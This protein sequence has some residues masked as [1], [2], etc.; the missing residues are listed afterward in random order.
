MLA[1]G[2]AGVQE[3][4]DVSEVSPN[5]DQE[6]GGRGSRIGDGQVIDDQLEAFHR[7]AADVG[8]LRAAG[9]LERGDLVVS[10]GPRCAGKAA[11]G[12]GNEREQL[13]VGAEDLIQPGCQLGRGAVPAGAQV[14]DVPAAC[15]ECGAQ[16]PPSEQT[17]ADGR[18]TASSLPA[19]TPCGPRLASDAIP[20]RPAAPGRSAVE[21]QLE[22]VRV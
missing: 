9:Q 17:C 20:R 18:T 7:A 6:V 22:L 21:V 15:L 16:D 11:A 12:R 19:W 3:A 1:E 8:G 10:T 14:G 5:S 13:A 2:G 4:A